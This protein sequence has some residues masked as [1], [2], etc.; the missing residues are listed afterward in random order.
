MDNCPYKC[1]SS[2]VVDIEEVAA[3]DSAIAT[4]DDV[5]WDFCSCSAMVN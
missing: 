1:D 5:V 4:S 3:K 2:V